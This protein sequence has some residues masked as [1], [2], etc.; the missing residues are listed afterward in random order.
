[1]M[2]LFSAQPGC[3]TS[4]QQHFSMRCL[5]EAEGGALASYTGTLRYSSGLIAD[6]KRT[7]AAL[8]RVSK[9]MAKV[10]SHCEMQISLA[11]A[12]LSQ[13]YHVCPCEGHWR[14]IG[15]LCRWPILY[16]MHDP[17]GSR[18]CCPTSRVAVFHWCKCWPVTCMQVTGHI[19]QELVTLHD[20]L[21]T[22]PVSAA[23]LW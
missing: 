20:S 18:L 3:Y 12:P 17:Q 7:A 21:A 2:C 1:M 9:M 22:M 19:A 6:Q 5:Q 14:C 8:V 23:D 15:L 11:A 13:V 16:I 10:W 4:F